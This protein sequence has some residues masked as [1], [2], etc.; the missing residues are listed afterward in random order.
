[1]GTDQFIGDRRIGG[2]PGDRREAA[3]EP[4][5]ERAQ[6]PGGAGDADDVRSRGGERDGDAEPEAPARA[7][8][9]RGPSGQVCRGQVCWDP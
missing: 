8:D 5:A 9:D 3:T 2:V 4:F 1:V 6:R 7:G